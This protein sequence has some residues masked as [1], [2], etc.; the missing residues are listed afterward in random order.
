LDDLFNIFG[1]NIFGKIIFEKTILDPENKKIILTLFKRMIDLNAARY[2]DLPTRVLDAIQILN[3][4]IL[5]NEKKELYCKLD[6][7]EK[8]KLLITEI[9]KIDLK[10]GNIN[11]N[12]C[13]FSVIKALVLKFIDRN[14]LKAEITKLKE[15]ASVIVID[16]FKDVF[17]FIPTK[18][19]EE[20]DKTKNLDRV[21]VEKIFRLLPIWEQS[22]MLRLIGHLD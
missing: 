13:R 14:K 18:V 3:L 5:P 1:E 6:L 21:S 20:I 4:V 17:P 16:F 12:C 10:S 11:K 19:Q 8:D 9:K 2:F 7:D 22:V 15:K